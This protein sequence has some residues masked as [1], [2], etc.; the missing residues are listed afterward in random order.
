MRGAT[1]SDL[2]PRANTSGG[3]KDLSRH[4]LPHLEIG[5]GHTTVHEPTQMILDRAPK[6]FV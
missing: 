3:R 5:T 6:I 2:D 1:A 4:N